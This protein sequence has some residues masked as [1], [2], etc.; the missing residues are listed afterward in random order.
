M[1][2]PSDWKDY[3]DFAAGIDTNRLPRTDAL[4]GQEFKIT[5]APDNSLT[6][7]F[8]TGDAMAWTD[9]AGEGEE[10][11]AEAEAPAASS[12]DDTV[13]ESEAEVAAKASEAGEDDLQS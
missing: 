12:D 2:K 11:G 10:D 9:A 6:Y 8:K 5:L 1:D 3:D 7:A 4:K 13:D